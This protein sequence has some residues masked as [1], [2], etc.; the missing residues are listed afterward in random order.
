MLIAKITY[1]T[2]VT[3]SSVHRIRERTP[4]TTSGFGV[5]PV[6]SRTVFSV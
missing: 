3:M 1:F 6:R 2:D 4:R 5:P